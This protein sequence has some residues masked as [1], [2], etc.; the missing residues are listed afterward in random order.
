MYNLKQAHNMYNL[1]F[2]KKKATRDFPGM[3][4]EY[5]KIEIITIVRTRNEN[6]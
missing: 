5:K 4:I 6:I 2:K 1:M 3:D